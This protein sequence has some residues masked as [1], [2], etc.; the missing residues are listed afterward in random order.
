MARTMREDGGSA[1]L[2]DELLEVR[3]RKGIDTLGSRRILVREIAERIVAAI[4]R[5]T[6]LVFEDLQW[7]DETVASR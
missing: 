7:A 4:D 1:S 2:G 5:P 6:L 3:G